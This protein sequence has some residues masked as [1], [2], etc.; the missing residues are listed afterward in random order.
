ML[1]EIGMFVLWI[2]GLVFVFNAEK[3]DK[4][5]PEGLKLA[6]CIL[7]AS[8]FILFGA[9]MNRGVPENNSYLKNGKIYE[10]VS[11]TPIKKEKVAVILHK[12][13]SDFNIY[14]ILDR[15]PP[16]VFVKTDDSEN[17][18]VAVKQTKESQ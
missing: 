12:K 16:K 2:L 14:I 1:M 5:T 15:V 9:I 4:N 18:Y 13:G 7:L 11:A 17:P 3:M 8:G 6:G 10:V